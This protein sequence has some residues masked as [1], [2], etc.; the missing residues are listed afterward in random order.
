[1][2]SLRGSHAKVSISSFC[3]N[4]LASLVLYIQVQ[5]TL[6]KTRMGETYDELVDVSG[7]QERVTADEW[8]TRVNLAAC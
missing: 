1:M 5:E 2:G 7:V 8:D 3:I 6:M 4:R